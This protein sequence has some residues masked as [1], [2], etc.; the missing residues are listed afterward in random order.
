MLNFFEFANGNNEIICFDFR[1]INLSGGVQ[2]IDKSISTPIDSLTPET[3]VEYMEVNEQ[4]AIA[5]RMRR[6]KEKEKERKQKL[7]R[8]PF[9]RLA[10][11][12]GL[13]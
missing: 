10:C 8:N 1:I 9:V 6:K 4:L 7:I 3:Q 2:V 13:V 12:C 11:F 5:D